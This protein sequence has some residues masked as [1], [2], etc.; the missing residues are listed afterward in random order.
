M[1]SCGSGGCGSSE[2]R[3]EIYKQANKQTCMWINARR[4]GF[5]PRC[6]SLRVE[7]SHALCQLSR[8][9]D[10]GPSRSMFK[11]S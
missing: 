4:H 10:P 6:I 9:P 11:G 5:R 7:V 8:L 2:G 1:Q 3:G